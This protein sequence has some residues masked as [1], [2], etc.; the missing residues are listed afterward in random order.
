L[1]IRCESSRYP[2]SFWKM[3]SAKKSSFVL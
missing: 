1:K 2:V 3:L